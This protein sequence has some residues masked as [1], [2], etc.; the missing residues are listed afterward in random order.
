LK[1]ETPV[2][3]DISETYIKATF[4]N[5]G[6]TLFPI[7]DKINGFVIKGTIIQAAIDFK[8]AIK[9]FK[10]FKINFNIDNEICIESP[11]GGYYFY[12]IFDNDC[13]YLRYTMQE[14]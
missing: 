14:W 7:V 12:M 9:F 5:E 4:V 11:H 3:N 1:R 8:E 2:V 10:R 13:N 6:I